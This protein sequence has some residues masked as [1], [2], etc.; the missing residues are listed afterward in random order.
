MTMFLYGLYLATGLLTGYQILRLVIWTVFG[1]PHKPGFIAVLG[2]VML[3]VAAIVILF[4]TRMAA[5]IGLV[6]TVLVWFFYI[7]VLRAYSNELEVTNARLQLV[8][9]A[10]VLLLVIS[11]LV[12]FLW[13]PFKTALPASWH[14]LFKPRRS[15]KLCLIASSA[16]VLALV[17]FHSSTTVGFSHEMQWY[18]GDAQGEIE[19][20]YPITNATCI[21][22]FFSEELR[23]YLLDTGKPLVDV[24]YAAVVDF[25]K[26]QWITLRRVSDWPGGNRGWHSSGVKGGSDSLLAPESACRKELLKQ[27][28]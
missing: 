13:G 28:E 5:W 7:P 14:A 6:G 23:G 3:F 12:S 4:R 11:T 21:E 16:A 24:H 22:T 9:L 8:S 19:L 27:L 20:S 1:I 2:S 17:A 15:L 25:G 10:P 18:Q 26:V